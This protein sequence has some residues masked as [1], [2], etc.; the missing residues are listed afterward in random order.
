MNMCKLYV[1]II[2]LDFRLEI[3]ASQGKAATAD[4]EALVRF[5]L[6]VIFKKP[7]SSSGNIAKRPTVSARNAKRILSLVMIAGPLF[8]GMNVPDARPSTNS[9]PPGQPLP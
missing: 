1:C 9:S 4:T 3:V 8:S 2:S 7:L 6:M 5:E